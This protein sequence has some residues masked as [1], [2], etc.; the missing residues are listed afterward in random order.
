MKT[1][2]NI[3]QCLSKYIIPTIVKK[4]E[5]VEDFLEK[6]KVS[7]NILFFKK[8]TPIRTILLYN[9]LLHSDSQNSQDFRKTTKIGFLAIVVDVGKS[10]KLCDLKEMKMGLEILTKS[11]NKHYQLV[12]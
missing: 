11:A 10:C 4:E 6:M 9:I 3:G 12:T 5:S 8:K 7:A 2:G 1:R